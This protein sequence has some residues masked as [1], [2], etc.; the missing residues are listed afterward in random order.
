MKT[1]SRTVT[2]TVLAVLC[3]LAW[4]AAQTPRPLPTALPPGPSSL[5][6]SIGFTVYDNVIFLI[7]EGSATRIDP[8]AIP[9]GHMMTLD[10]RLEPLPPGIQLPGFDAAASDAPQPRVPHR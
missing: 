10:G 6:G 9:P 5:S 2:G 8:A 7:R 1:I 3:L 4:S